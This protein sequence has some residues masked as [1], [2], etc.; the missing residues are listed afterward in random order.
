MDP[1]SRRVRSTILVTLVALAAVACRTPVGLVREDA[2]SVHRALTANVLSSGEPSPRAWQ[3]L[4]RRDLADLYRRD[5]VQALT[6]LH[7]EAVAHDRPAL[8]ATLSELA[9]HHAKRGGRSWY[10]A[11]A[12]YAAAFLGRAGALDPLDPTVRLVADLYNLGLSQG[13]RSEDGLEVVLE[14][15]LRRLPFGVLDLKVDDEE[16]HWGGFRMVRF[17]P[18]AE[19]EVRGLRNRY[20]SRGIGLPLAA[21]LAPGAEAEPPPGHE[22]IPPSTRVPVTALVLIPG[23]DAALR[24]GRVEGQLELYTRDESVDVELGGRKLALEAEPSAALAAALEESSFWVLERQGFL[25]GDFGREGYTGLTM[26]QP[27]HSGRIPVVFVHG[28][29]SSTARWANMVN[30]LIVSHE[31]HEHFQFWFFQYNTG[32]PIL[33]SAARLRRALRDAVAALDPDGRDPALRRMVVVGHSQGGL[34]AKL[35]VVDSG[36]DFWGLLSRVPMDEL[37]LTPQARETFGEALFF[38]PLPFVRSVIFIATPFQGSFLAKRPLS[39]FVGGLVSAPHDLVEA[40]VGLLDRNDERVLLRSL[41]DLPSSIDDMT[42]ANRFLSVLGSKRIADGVDA[43]TIIA[44][45][46]DGPPEEGDDGVVA[47]RSAHLDG[48]ASEYVV[49]SGHSTQSS[50]LTIREVRRILA[51]HAASD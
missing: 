1:A 14:P 33:Y 39:R 50:P 16:F 8:L 27:Y 3:Q 13:L 22:F 21:S 46:G 15:G 19:Y 7:R 25:S 28:T 9:Y 32:N 11:S 48:V 26:F 45:S 18:V 23:V 4:D 12:V 35:L 38:E 6:L 36:A 24:S 30:E 49:R 31:I 29:A 47:Y 17:V 43:H 37:D 51:E 41:D 2:Q 44:V 10:L 5:P 34:L 20:R 40:G 42:S